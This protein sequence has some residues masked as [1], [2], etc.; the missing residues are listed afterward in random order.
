MAPYIKNLEWIQRF[1]E[2]MILQMPEDMQNPPPDNDGHFGYLMQFTDGN[3]IDLQIEPLEKLKLSLADSQTVILLDKDGIVPPIPPASDR[4]YLP[5]PPTAKLF[6][7]CCNEFWWV[8]VYVAKGLWREELPYA[9]A[10]QDDYVR[11]Q[12][13]DM[14]AWHIGIKTNFSV[15]P[16]KEGK[17]IQRFLEPELWEILLKTYA[18]GSYEHTWEALFNMG[19]LFRL[20]ALGVAEHFGFDYNHGEDQRVSAY[21]QH[22][23]MLPRDAK[24]IY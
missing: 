16:G 8:S 13:M 11:P 20:V 24:E 21:L 7:D 5:K 9:K 17:Y 14:L 10:F 15:S 3:R 2:L 4:N 18:D 19:E 12:L 23:Q 22:I 1:G 6:A